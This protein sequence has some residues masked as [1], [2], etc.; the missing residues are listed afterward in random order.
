MESRDRGVVNS[1]QVKAG[2]RTYFFDV[3]STRSGDHYL[4]ITESK[5]RFTEDGK[6]VYDKHKVFVYREDFDKF[7]DAFQESVDFIHQ[8]PLPA[9]HHQNN[10]HYG[11]NQ[12]GYGQ[13]DGGYQS[14]NTDAPSH[15]E[16][17]SG[18]DLNFE[19]LA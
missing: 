3:K 10:N 8:Q 4:T 19:D 7:M 17:H 13:Q 18:S 11:N 2:K 12:Q 14:R 16:S 5:K 15:N 6:F 1:R 9:N